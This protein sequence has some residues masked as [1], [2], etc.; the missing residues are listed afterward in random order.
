[1]LTQD[2][3]YPQFFICFWALCGLRRRFFCLGSAGPRP[4]RQFNDLLMEWNS[5][6]QEANALSPSSPRL[7]EPALFGGWNERAPFFFLF[8]FF[9]FS[10][11]SHS[12]FL[13]CLLRKTSPDKCT[14]QEDHNAWVLSIFFYAFLH[15]KPVQVY[16]RIVLP[17]HSIE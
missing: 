5:W 4:I 16:H 8:F 15:L 7:S 13:P 2:N 10:W 9:S 1:M 3:F 12:W 14:L 17:T 6:D 11:Q